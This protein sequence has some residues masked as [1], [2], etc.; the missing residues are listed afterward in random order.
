[1]RRSFSLLFFLLLI[2][3]YVISQVKVVDNSAIPYC[4]NADNCM[5]LSNLSAE[6]V[7]SLYLSKSDSKPIKVNDLKESTSYG[8]QLNFKKDNLQNVQKFSIKITTLRENE[9]LDFYEKHNPEVLRV[10]FNDLKDQVGKNGHTY[11]DYKK[12]YHQYKHL[13]CRLYKQI[14]DAEGNLTDEMSY[15]LKQYQ[16]SERKDQDNYLATTGLSDFGLSKK[17]LSTDKWNYWINFLKDL[18]TRGYITLIEYNTAP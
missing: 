2:C 18:E 14:E 10:I 15:L 16:N 9:C 6:E 7:L 12:I 13:G 8:Y 3:N 1:M 17:K 5:W 11:S 4:D